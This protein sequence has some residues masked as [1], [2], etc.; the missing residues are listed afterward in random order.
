MVLSRCGLVRE[1]DLG[2]FTTQYLIECPQA[3][4]ATQAPTLFACV[5]HT[6]YRGNVKAMY[7]GKKW[8]P[9]D[10]AICVS[11]HMD[12]QKQTFMLLSSEGFA[13]NEVN[14]WPLW[15]L[16]DNLLWTSPAS[17]Q[18]GQ[19]EGIKE[20][21]AQWKI[22]GNRLMNWAES[23][24]KKGIKVNALQKLRGRERWGKSAGV[25]Q[26][27]YANE[28]EAEIGRER[29]EIAERELL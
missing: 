1:W 14:K 6:Y 11:T 2:K 7:H 22:G 20:N 17:T 28:L 10:S 5:F 12:V 3:V 18:R 26:G 19:D 15:E 24:W 27:K 4:T 8:Q 25:R 13:N 16:A 23:W 29:M 21:K 9:I